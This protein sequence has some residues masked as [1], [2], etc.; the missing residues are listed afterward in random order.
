MAKHLEIMRE[1]A[2]HASVIGCLMN[3]S[4]PGVADQLV[5]LEQAAQTAGQRLRILNASTKHE[6]NTSFPDADQ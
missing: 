2:P 6:I 1:L 3:P 4:F 5:E